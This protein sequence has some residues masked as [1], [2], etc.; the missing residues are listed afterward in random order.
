V[1]V[2]LMIWGIAN[3]AV[4]VPPERAGAAEQREV[5]IAEITEQ[6]SSRLVD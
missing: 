4:E 5:L 3:T 2:D 1:L 6:A